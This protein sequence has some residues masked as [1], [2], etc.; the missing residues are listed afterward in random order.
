[1]I[2]R[3]WDAIRAAGLRP[4]TMLFGLFL[5]ACVTIVG[6]ARP[7]YITYT[8]LA[9]MYLL[10]V[11]VMAVRSG[12]W[13]ALVVAVVSVTALD[14]FFLPPVYSLAVNTPEDALLL[15]FFA[16]VAVTA[17]SLA[18]RLR[19]QML[20]ARQHANTTT[21]LYR[22]ASKLAATVTID[23]IISAVVVQ[24][25]NMLKCRATV[26]LGNEA[27]K[28][29]VGILLPLRAA[30]EIVAVM[31]VAPAE[32]RG[33]SGDDRRLLD[34]LAELAAAA[35]GRQLLADKLAQLGIEQ[36]ADRLRSALLDSIA[37]DLTAPISSVA[38]ALTTLNND[39][40]RLE[41]A[42]RREII[43]EAE[44][45][46]Q[47]LH[48]F[49]S[50]LVN[51]SRLEAGTIRL[52]RELVDIGDLVGSALARARN[53]LGARRVA[54]NLPPD[55]PPLKIDFVLMEQV[56]FNLLENAAK[57]SPIDAAI[58]ITAQRV[59]A[60]IALLIADNGPGFLAEES[61][62][63]FAK[64]YR[65][66]SMLA[67]RHGTGLGLAICRGFVEAHGGTITAK[68]RPGGGAL[69]TIILPADARPN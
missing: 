3:F 59:E 13:P 68:N 65:A 28:A 10:V 61:E 33:I 25:S 1:M 56:V 36:A 5:V 60:G 9:L 46:A 66:P 45:E 54:I 38:S 2:G 63:I 7:P 30:G 20:I 15:A 53:P 51:M 37:H 64:F 55:L 44:R 52:Q 40:P 41:D 58:E 62:R 39:Y 29:A 31:S 49:S 4:R 26:S 47:R 23:A 17:S 67:G 24:V 22:F 34:T 50:N 43:G 27:S 8:H 16:V 18:A 57:Y 42:T 11:L 69:F 6:E 14:F 21:E 48:R 32:Y 12:L 35:I 19:E